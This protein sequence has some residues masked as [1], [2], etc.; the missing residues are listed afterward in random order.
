MNHHACHYSSLTY[1]ITKFQHVNS[2]T[3]TKVK[4]SSRIIYNYIFHD[5]NLLDSIPLHCDQNCFRFFIQELCV[6]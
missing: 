3:F 2:C 1:H 4:I 5:Q 6:F